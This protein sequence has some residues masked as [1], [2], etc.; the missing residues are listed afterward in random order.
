MCKR[1]LVE[2]RKMERESDGRTIGWVPGESTQKRDF[3]VPN[4]NPGINKEPI[5][6]RAECPSN[7]ELSRDGRVQ[8]C[9][10]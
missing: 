7:S 8:S 2:K 1:C 5:E 10:I 6:N 9:Q 3:R 4:I